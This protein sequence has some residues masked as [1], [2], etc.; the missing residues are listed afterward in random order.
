MAQLVEPR[1]LS[2]LAPFLVIELKLEMI[3]RHLS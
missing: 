1:R 3:S 2:P